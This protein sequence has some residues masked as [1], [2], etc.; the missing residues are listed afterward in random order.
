MGAVFVLALSFPHAITA[1]ARGDSARAPTPSTVDTSS[2]TAARF[3]KRY[4]ISLDLAHKI[5]D[6]AVKEGVDPELGFRLVRVESLFKP[7]AR[8]SAGALGLVQLMP[9]T[10]RSVDRSLRTEEEILKPE[11]NLRVGFRYL[12]QMI[13]RYRGDIRLG[14]LAYNRG[15]TSVDRAL[16]RGADPENGYSHKVLGT[17][18]ENPYRGSGVA[19]P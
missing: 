15:E 11:N 13:D 12:R 4:R 5:V 2:S 14:L 10:A 3:A 19:Q 16:K 18:G 1:Q 6:A 17:K 7:N 9:G 8:G